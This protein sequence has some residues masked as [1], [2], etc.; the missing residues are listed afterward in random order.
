MSGGFDF[1]A[2]VMAPFR[3]QPGLRRL[4]EAA[5]QLTPSQPGARHQREK[6]AVLSRFA[7]Q[8][9]VAAAGFDARPALQALNQHAAQVHPAAWAWDGEAATALQLGVRVSA[10]GRTLERLHAGTFGLGD[11][12]SR[13]VALQAPAWRWPC[14][15]C[16]AFEEDLAIVDAR[17]ATVPWMA[18]TL[19]SHWAPEHKVG[20][21]FAQIHAPVADGDLLRRAGAALTTLVAGTEHWERFVWNVTDQPRLH[22]HPD[23]VDP[24]RWQQPVASDGLPRA[25]LR[26]ERQ[27]FLPVPDGRQSV[28]TIRVHVQAL[29]EAVAGT[30][31]AQRLADAV[32]SMSPAVL[33]YRGLTPI[34]DALLQWLALR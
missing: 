29:D 14:L 12:I 11:E 3:M 25:W 21:H 6:L 34:R 24:A 9:L 16:L 33:D 22:A 23:R 2:A 8:A 26:T 17:D 7:E 13:C 32:R 28:F 18:V 10:D 20:R 15:M 5:P 27:T 19:P 1:D 30:G 31:K 4:P